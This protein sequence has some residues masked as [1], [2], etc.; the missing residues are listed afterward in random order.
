MWNFLIL[1]RGVEGGFGKM[2]MKDIDFMPGNPRYCSLQSSC[3][4]LSSRGGRLSRGFWSWGIS[5]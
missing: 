5:C 1:G 3:C 4:I 2:L